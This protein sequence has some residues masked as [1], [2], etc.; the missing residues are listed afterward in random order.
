MNKSESIKEIAPALAKF[1]SEVTNPANTA[2]NPFFK[3]KY[4]PLNEI[5]NLVR[6]LLSK[7]GLSVIQMP[8]GDGQEVIITTLL[9]HS[10]GEWIESCPLKMK[11]AKN[12]PQG[13]GS[14]ITYGRRYALTAILGI[15]SEDD[16]DGNSATGNAHTQKKS[17]QKVQG[18]APRND[19]PKMASEVQ[20]KKIY[21]IARQVGVSA[22]SVKKIYGVEHLEGLTMAQAS[23]A[24]KKLE[25][26]KEQAGA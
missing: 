6:P 3:S 19:S 15:S 5:L 7:H 26:R 17:P 20:I 22:D 2:E 13:I 14:A 16:D 4:S 12:D 9:M 11:P 1:Q 24:I 23:E 8:S 21:A 10:S 25:E 18:D